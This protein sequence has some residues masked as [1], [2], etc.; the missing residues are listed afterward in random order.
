M[1]WAS[2]NMKG[3][4]GPGKASLVRNLIK[5]NNV[6][7][8]SLQET[9][10]SNMPDSKIRGFWNNSAM[11]YVKVDAAGR[12][13]GLL[14]IWNPSLFKKN[15][16][17]VDQ[18]FIL[19]KGELMGENTELVVVNIYAP[20]SGTERRQVWDKLL[21]LRDSTLGMWLIIGDF[22]EVRVPEDRWNSNFDGNNAQ[23]F[24]NF[25]ST[26]GLLEYP[27]SGRKFTF[28]SGDGKIEQDR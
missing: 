14:S 21:D 26:A 13:G 24:N 27:M 20:S 22:N 17:I 8:I 5:D 3:A 9:Q 4:G 11:E 25:I 10:M 12:S 18:N 6:G 1:N 28:M 19:V 16:E 23:H 15:M 7:F 2:L